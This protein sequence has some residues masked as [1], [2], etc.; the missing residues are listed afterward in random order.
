MRVTEPTARSTGGA[1]SIAA[2]VSA[3]SDFRVESIEFAPFPQ[4]FCAA[5]AYELTALNSRI[6]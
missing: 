3:V 4:S 6:G 5:V 2:I 1:K